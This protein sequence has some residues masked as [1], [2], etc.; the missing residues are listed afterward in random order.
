[1]QEMRSIKQKLTQNAI[2]LGSWIQMPDPFS[3]EIMARA[4]FDWLAIDLEHGFINLDTAFRLI[5]TI[6]NAG[7]LPIVRLHEND[8]ST[9]R[10]VMDA[11]AG[12]VIVPM[13]NTAE[14]AR[15]A[16]DAVKYSPEGKRSFGL[17]RAHEFGL[18][19]DTYVHEINT[20]SLVVIQI[21]H[22][23]A[24]GNLDAILAVPGID[25]IIIGPYDLSGSM[26]I[27][28]KFDDP[29]F[30]SAV[31]QIINKVKQ[32]PIALGIH[33]VHPSEQDLKERIRQG[34]TFIGYGMDTL[35]LQNGARNA[36]QEARS[37]FP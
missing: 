16:V 18:N 35:F 2:T 25:A 28:G 22:K 5:Q 17:G 32:S 27:P 1:M 29:R 37:R 21:E 26:G 9:I 14:E 30:I 23:D 33:I 15:K 8:P 10:R 6:D 34:C 12:G 31:A 13:I 7:A 4:G 36:V 19:F 11:G 20:T 3:A 24:L